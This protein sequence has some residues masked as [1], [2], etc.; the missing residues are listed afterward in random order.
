[1]D[2]FRILTIEEEIHVLR[3]MSKGVMTWYMDMIVLLWSSVSCFYL[4]LM[5]EKAGPTGTDVNKK[6]LLEVIHSSCPSLMFLASS[7][8]FCVFLK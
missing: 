6:F 5:I 3:Q 1:M 8:K 2:L 7:L 4:F